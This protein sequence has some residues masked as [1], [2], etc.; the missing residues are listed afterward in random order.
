MKKIPVSHLASSWISSNSREED[1]LMARDLDNYPRLEYLTLSPMGRLMAF[2]VLPCPEASKL[3]IWDLERGK[4]VYSHCASEYLDKP[5]GWFSEDELLM[6]RR[7][8]REDCLLSSSLFGMDLRDGREWPI[9]V[10]D[11]MSPSFVN[12]ARP[13]LDGLNVV[14][15]KVDVGG[16]GSKISKSLWTVDKCGHS[17]KIIIQPIEPPI[18]WGIGSNEQG[19]TVVLSSRVKVMNGRLIGGELF[20]VTLSQPPVAKVVGP[21]LADIASCSFLSRSLKVAVVEGIDGR[22]KLHLFNAGLQPSE[23]KS[24]DLPDSATSR[25]IWLPDGRLLCWGRRC[26]RVV[27]RESMSTSELALEDREIHEIAVS[28]FAA[29]F[30]VS[31]QS[32][33]YLFDLDT[34]H[35]A[36]VFSLSLI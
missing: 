18:I 17:S 4:L 27:E 10:C 25:V 20:L 23:V 22:L 6:L 29:Q 19:R 15:T 32:T 16:E 31:S 13:T 28:P 1:A 14:F 3:C 7:P 2:Q 36:E 11:A 8:L 5:V 34:G 24:T 21:Q 35:V 33:I 30:F 26:V 9:V 12:A